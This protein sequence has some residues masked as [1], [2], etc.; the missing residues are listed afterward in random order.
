MQFCNF[1]ID[2]VD[3]VLSWDL[4]DESVADAVS[5]E[6]SHLAGIDSEQP[7]DDVD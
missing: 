6:A 4:P 2:A 7:R 5:A 3:R 1:V